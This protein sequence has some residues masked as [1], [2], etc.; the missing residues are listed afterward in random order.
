[1]FFFLVSQVSMIITSHDLLPKFRNILQH[2]DT[3]T[4]IVFFEDQVR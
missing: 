2:T 4:K 3:V 1:M